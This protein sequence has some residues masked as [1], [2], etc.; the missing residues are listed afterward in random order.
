MSTRPSNQLVPNQ[1]LKIKP[2]RPDLGLGQHGGSV[3][4]GL[5]CSRPEDLQRTLNTI[6]CIS[7][8]TAIGRTWQNVKYLRVALA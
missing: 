7:S 1:R 3:T 8:S 5:E 6:C 4:Q 2:V